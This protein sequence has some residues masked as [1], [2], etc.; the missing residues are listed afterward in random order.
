MDTIL[1]PN[2]ALRFA[3][4]V[5]AEPDDE[6]GGGLL[7]MLLPTPMARSSQERS[8]STLW[9]LRNG[10]AVEIEIVRGG[11]DGR[12]T[13]IRSGLQEGDLVMVGQRWLSR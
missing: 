11:T 1:V 2:A 12:V 13:E 9:V 10:E 7:A 5:E 4:R 3:P 8:L 6:G